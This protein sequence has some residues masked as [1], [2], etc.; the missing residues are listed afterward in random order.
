MVRFLHQ[1]EKI[2]SI[3]FSVFVNFVL[4]PYTTSQLITIKLEL[5]AGQRRSYPSVFFSRYG[6]L[7]LTMY[8]AGVFRIFLRGFVSW[9]RDAIRLDEYGFTMESQGNCTVNILFETTVAH[10]CFGL[11]FFTYFMYTYIRFNEIYSSMGLTAKQQN[12]HI[13]KQL[14]QVSGCGA[15]QSLG[16][17]G[18]LFLR[19]CAQKL[20]FREIRVIYSCILSLSVYVFIVFPVLLLSSHYSVDTE[21]PPIYIETLEEER[22][23]DISS[24]TNSDFSFN[25][26]VES[27]TSIDQSLE[28]LANVDES[29]VESIS[30]LVA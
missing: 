13:I 25:R 4:Q 27:K 19:I 15:F 7:P 28:Y 20:S 3:C 17:V 10:L 22:E 24:I 30:S 8:I 21:S 14:N 11:F 29:F 16:L 6:C 1:G 26:S 18:L 2:L 23:S 12:A 5:T 9:E